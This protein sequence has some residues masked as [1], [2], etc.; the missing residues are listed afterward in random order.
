MKLFVGTHM[1]Y[2]KKV[3]E[4]RRGEGEQKIATYFFSDGV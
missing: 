3:V 2:N 4:K 1:L